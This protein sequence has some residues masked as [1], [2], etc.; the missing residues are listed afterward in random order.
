MSQE[1]QPYANVRRPQN[2]GNQIDMHSIQTR[3]I[4][5]QGGYD[6]AY[7]FSAVATPIASPV[8]PIIAPSTP[9]VG[10]EDIELYFDSTQSDASSDYSIGELRWNVPNLNNTA[11]I[12][13]CIQL[14]L[15]EFYFP[16]IYLTG[17][18]PD[19]FYFRRVFLEFQNAP[20]NQAVLA[21]NNN[22]FHFEFRVENINGQAVRLVPIKKSFFFQRPIISIT[23][24]Q[25]RFMV[26]PTT[27]N[28]AVY[29]KIPLPADTVPIVSLLTAGVGYNPIRFQITSADLTN[30][31]GLVGSTG[32]P[33][34]AVFISNFNSTD[35]TLNTAVNDQNGVYIA[36]IIDDTTFELS[37]INGSTITAQVTAT[38]YIP[39]NRIAF[40]VRFTTVRDQLTNYIDV[41]HD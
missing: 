14:H 35:P 27:S 26:P 9:T 29:K 23:D 20:S 24:F 37:G 33:G 19:F 21:P 39:K 22:K 11:E 36:T 2:R 4:Y 28:A 15:D 8:A 34:L 18:T 38:M 5:K 13:N 32:T 30:I 31:L 16:K 41:T 40:P 6:P 12:K 3:E 25:I 10:F 1:R 17:N 7:Q